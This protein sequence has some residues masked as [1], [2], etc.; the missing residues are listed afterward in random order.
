MTALGTTIFFLK[1]AISCLRYFN[2]INPAFSKFLIIFLVVA[3]TYTEKKHNTIILY[4]DVSDD[5]QM[6]LCYVAEVYDF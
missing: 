6:F 3:F 1:Q 2:N 5:F 4:Y